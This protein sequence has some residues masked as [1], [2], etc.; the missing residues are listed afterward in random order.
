V[1]S[2]PYSIDKVTA[3]SGKAFTL[4]N[5]P[6]YYVGILEKIIEGTELQV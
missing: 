5:I 2:K 3:P 4:H 6:F 1:W